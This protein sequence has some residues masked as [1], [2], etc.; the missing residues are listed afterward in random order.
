MVWADQWEWHEQSQAWRRKTYEGESGW[1]DWQTDGVCFPLAVDSP[2]I[3][4][5]DWGNP[6]DKPHWHIAAWVVCHATL[7]RLAGRTVTRVVSAFV[8]FL[9]ALFQC[10]IDVQVGNGRLNYMNGYVSKDHDA[11]DVGLGE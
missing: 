6:I 11:V 3:C 5:A 7:A 1:W 4:A 9:A 10:E 2:R 8:K